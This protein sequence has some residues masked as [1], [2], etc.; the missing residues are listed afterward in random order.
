[1]R[2]LS[3]CILKLPVAAL[4]PTKLPVW[5]EEP[6]L[7][8]QFCIK[9]NNPFHGVLRSAQVLVVFSSSHFECAVVPWALVLLF[10]SSV[11]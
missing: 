2:C 11:L 6:W 3:R 7:A 8:W 1:M 10:F 4:P 9:G 5:F